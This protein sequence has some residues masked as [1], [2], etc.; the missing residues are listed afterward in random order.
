MRELKQQGATGAQE[1]DRFPVDPPRDRGRTKNAFN[2]SGG[3]SLDDIKS[4]LQIALRDA[5]GVQ[6]Q[7]FSS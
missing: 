3:P 1:E 5:L 6:L 4:R 7:T 2:R